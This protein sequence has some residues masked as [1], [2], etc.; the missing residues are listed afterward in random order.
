MGLADVSVLRA[1]GTA[2]FQPLLRLVAVLVVVRHH[3]H[4]HLLVCVVV[5]VVV[6]VFC[7]LFAVVVIVVCVLFLVIVTVA[8]AI[9]AVLVY[10]FCAVW[11]IISIIFCIANANGGTAFLLTDGSIMIQERSSAFGQ[12]V[13]VR[14]W[15]KLTPDGS[16][17]YANGSWS[18]LADSNQDRLYFASAVLADGR[19]IVCG[20]EYSDASGSF[21][22]D[23]T[24]TCEIYDPV[25]NSWNT[26]PAPTSTANPATTWAQ[27]GDSPCTVLPGRH[28]PDLVVH[29]NGRRQIRPNEQHLEHALRPHGVLRERGVVRADA[30]QHHRVGKLHQSHTDDRLHHRDRQLGQWQ[31]SSHRRDGTNSRR[32]E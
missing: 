13:G 2:N 12:S 1:M 27:V 19:V 28:V 7:V 26:L 29:D 18:R 8:C 10:V 17:S 15:W 24:N 25:A 6:T 3:H 4:R 21:S 20:G 23:D 22:Q 30:R 16:G 11:S 9:W 31:C 14:R 5:A 32:G